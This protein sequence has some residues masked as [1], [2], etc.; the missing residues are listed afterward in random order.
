[1]LFVPLQIRS[2]QVPA[3]ANDHYI[4][5]TVVGI[6]SSV[7]DLGCL[8]GIRIFSIPDPWPKKF[9]DPGSE[10]KNLIILTP[11][12]CSQALGNMIRDVH[13]GSFRILIFYPSRSLD[14]GVKKVWDPDL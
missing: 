3:K 13:T 10:S 12:N 14:P 4:T 11:K 2:I 8:S 5:D 7:P 1:M 6:Y 9:P